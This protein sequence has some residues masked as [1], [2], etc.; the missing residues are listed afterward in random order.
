M[1]A[2]VLA[3]G[4]IGAFIA[5]FQPREM[6][7]AL[8]AT[9]VAQALVPVIAMMIWRP[10]ITGGLVGVFILN[11]FF[12]ALWVVSALLFRHAGDPRSKIRGEERGRGASR[13]GVAD[14][15]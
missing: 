7:R 11:T 15:A 13:E 6:A 14:K 4:L 9:A 1:Y 2:G 12:V 10:P 3:V 8:F 5:Q